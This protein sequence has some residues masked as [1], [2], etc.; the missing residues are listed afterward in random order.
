MAV[1]KQLC[2]AELGYPKNHWYVA[3]W[4]H[5]VGR[6]L[7]SRRLLG[8]PVVLY[9]TEEG[10]AVALADM[11]PHRGAPLSKGA[12]VGNNVQCV[13]HG[14]EFDE[15][16]KCDKIP[17][18]S[19]IPP[20]LCVRSYP[21][22]EK[23]QWL[24]IWMGD[25]DKA[26]PNLI[27]DHRL[28]GTEL[29]GYQG[30]P[31]FF[32]EI[33]A[34]YTLM[35]ENLLD[36]THATFLHPGLL[37]DSGELTNG[38]F[39]F[40]EQDGV[41]K[42]RREMDCR[43]GPAVAKLFDVQEGRLY[44]RTLTCETYPPNLSLARGHFIDPE[45]PEEAPKEFVATAAITPAGPN[46]VYVFQASVTSYPFEWSPE[47][48]EGLRV[49]VAQDKD[50]LEAIQARYEDL[51]MQVNELSVKTDLPGLRFRKRIADMV[52]QERELAH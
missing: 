29:P 35:H 6:N 50:V 19:E 23:W 32:M 49:I 24:W 45:H 48:I 39:S 10:E 36:T 13:Y 5:E 20:N 12:L 17:S 28:I 30:T 25:A 2:P 14:L 33:N 26:D 46:S 51:D 38:T 44:K 31:M 18:Q 27:P 47:A 22:V 4:S 3:A 40:E 42:L 21:V 52:N 34:N 16:G 8:L 9:R 41:L 7:F 43:P 11:C 1:A 37:D 15:N